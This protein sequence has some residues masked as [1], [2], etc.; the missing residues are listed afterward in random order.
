[1]HPGTVLWMEPKTPM[2]ALAEDTSQ[3]IPAQGTPQLRAM[4]PA[5]GTDQL[6]VIEHALTADQSQSHQVARQGFVKSVANP[7][8]VSLCGHCFRPTIWSAL[9]VK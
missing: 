9:N 2:A 7:S 8:Q 1:M 5:I 4:Q 6:R 3:T